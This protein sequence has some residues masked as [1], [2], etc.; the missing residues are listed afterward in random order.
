MRK[1]AV[2]IALLLPEEIEKK[3]KK[4]Q[5]RENIPH[6]SLLMGAID[7]KI[8][9]KIKKVV[10]K[11]KI[12]KIELEIEKVYKTEMTGSRALK[13]KKIPKLQKLHG[14]LAGNLKK[15]FVDKPDKAMFYNEEASENNLKI[16]ENYI[17]NASYKNFSPHITLG[18]GINI[19]DINIK[20]K[21]FDALGIAVCHLG[22][23]CSCREILFLVKIE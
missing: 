13:I 16:V 20:K 2:D 9:P 18:K 17:K 10:E 8:L 6:I 5:T 23:H 15:Y 1:I 22:R 12:N 4:I 14:Y 11:Y 7:T 21:R 3:I 19:K